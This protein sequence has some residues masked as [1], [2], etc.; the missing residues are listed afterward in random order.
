MFR[1]SKLLN[2]I[3]EIK[4][5]QITANV[6]NSFISHVKTE[7]VALTELT[8]NR[9]ILYQLAELSNFKPYD[10]L[11]WINRFLVR[12]FVFKFHVNWVGSWKK[13]GK[14]WNDLHNIE[15]KLRGVQYKLQSNQ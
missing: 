13:V 12:V 2:Q 6:F 1:T 5:E 7:A 14:Y 9:E 8:N 3:S 4:N 15:L 11:T 10:D